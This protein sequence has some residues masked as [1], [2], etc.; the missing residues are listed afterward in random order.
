MAWNILHHLYLLNA[1][2]FCSFKFKILPTN[3]LMHLKLIRKLFARLAYSRESRIFLPID[4]D[5]Y[6]LIAVIFWT[7]HFYKDKNEYKI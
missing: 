7:Y 1:D 5:F 3:Y 6:L 2:D 4:F